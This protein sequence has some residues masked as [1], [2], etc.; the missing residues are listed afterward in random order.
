MLKTISYS[1]IFES[2]LLIGSTASLPGTYDRLAALDDQG[3]P[4]VPAS[5]VRGRVKDAIRT[6]LRDNCATWS[7]FTVCPG[8]DRPVT[9]TGDGELPHCTEDAGQTLCPLC[10]IF[11]APGGLKRGFEF[12][13]AHYPAGVVV[14]LEMA[15]GRNPGDLA[16]ASVARRARN[17]RD[18]EL[19]RAR[20]DH[21][22]V[23]G[24]A[25]IMASLEGTVRETPAHLAYDEEIRT[26]D[27]QL[28]LLGLRLTT[29]LG[30]TRNR[31]Y[32]RCELL[33]AG[34]WVQEVEKLLRAWQRRPGGGE[35]S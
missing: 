7:Q 16:A 4:Y 33:P 17:K 18:E 23:D 20:E 3:L 35:T 28:L 11:G 12:S 24:V 2:P 5:S 22:F 10:R 15:F 14:S 19:R 29:E 26:L 30:A 6:F 27:Y 34:D 9:R 31:G 21:L 25:E 1:I 8:Q 13:G 32:G